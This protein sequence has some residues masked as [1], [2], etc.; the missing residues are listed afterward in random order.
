LK[1]EASNIELFDFREQVEEEVSKQNKQLE[2]VIK[3]NIENYEAK[4]AEAEQNY[5]EISAAMQVFEERNLFDFIS[6]TIPTADELSEIL[7]VGTEDPTIGVVMAGL[8]VFRKLT[9]EVGEGFSYVQMIK[10]RDYIY[11]QIQT[12]QQELETLNQRKRQVEINLGDLANISIIE[13]ERFPFTEQV[14]NLAT[15]YD[16]FIQDINS[17]LNSMGQFDNYDNMLVLL[18]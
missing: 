12:Y 5:A 11:G 4:K 7:G 1:R 3:P 17:K 9:H 13:S 18:N 2:E 8:E 6:E 15:T 10:A 14:R 16:Y